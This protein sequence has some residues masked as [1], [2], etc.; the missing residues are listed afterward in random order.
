MFFWQINSILII[1]AMDNLN[2]LVTG[3]AG[4]IGSHIIKTLLVSGN[5][6]VVSIDKK[7]S[8]N[9]SY[10]KGCI[11]IKGNIGNK[12]TVKDIFRKYKIDIVIHLASL[13][14]VEESMKNPDLYF[15]NNIIE[16]VS[17]LEVM[18]EEG[19]NKIM[20][21]S[22]AAVY[23]STKNEIKPA[24][25]YG[26]TKFAFENILKYYSQENGLKCIIFRLF[27][28]AGADLSGD[29]IEC[30]KP[31]THLIPC[32][33]KSINLNKPVVIFAQNYSTPDGSC[34][35]DYI[36]VNDVASAFLLAIP[37]FNE[38]KYDIFDIGFGKGYSVKEVVDECFLLLKKEPKI[39]YKDRRAGDSA[40]LLSDNK[41]AKRVLGWKPKY[42]LKD[43][44]LHTVN[45]QS[46][47]ET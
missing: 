37:K 38:I 8:I 18:K 2:I 26:L 1:T 13:I 34:I 24:N 23:G 39:I 15:R 22:S 4:Y 20:F 36:H 10:N 3:G 45:S 7:K 41:K 19:I 27:N 32:T 44:I 35:R 6:N 12:K 47:K 42:N 16:S 17:L 46:Y 21:S 14:S 25:V 5:L 28:V 29:L 9:Q 31:E 33:I 40:I 11:F 43:I 30:H